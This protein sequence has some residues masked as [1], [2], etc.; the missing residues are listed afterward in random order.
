M[1]H[2]WSASSMGKSDFDSTNL[3][4]NPGR[5]GRKNGASLFDLTGSVGLLRPF[6]K[7]IWW[8]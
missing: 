1:I 3:I 4:S 8:L 5:V 2:T 6:K 7:I